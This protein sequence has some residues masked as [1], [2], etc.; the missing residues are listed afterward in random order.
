MKRPRIRK[1]WKCEID[2]KCSYHPDDESLDWFE[3]EDECKSACAESKL[4]SLP[5]ELL[6]EVL[7]Y[8]PMATTLTQ[9]SKKL[10]LEEKPHYSDI[11]EQERQASQIKQL[12][13][14]N[15]YEDV[16][17]MMDLNQGVLATKYLIDNYQEIYK[18]DDA[19]D[20][21]PLLTRFNE[22]F[23]N[24]V[25]EN[26]KSMYLDALFE[27]A[28]DVL[29]ENLYMITKKLIYLYLF[30]IDYDPDNDYLPKIFEKCEIKSVYPYK[31]NEEVIELSS[32]K[33][34]K[35]MRSGEVFDQIME[36]MYPYKNLAILTSLIDAEQFLF[37][38]MLGMNDEYI[39][40]LIKYE[41]LLTD[42]IFNAILRATP[43]IRTVKGYR[44]YDDIL[45]RLSDY[46]SYQLIGFEMKYIKPGITLDETLQHL[47][48]LKFMIKTNLRASDLGLEQLLRDLYD[49]ILEFYTEFELE[50][51]PL[52]RGA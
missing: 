7:T 37:F 12:F 44:S 36:T 48:I 51:F 41:V 8:E 25:L 4:E 33:Y 46:S 11:I 1:H 19:I 49:H 6:H 40:N 50:S 18:M 10:H 2:H 26:R 27:L 17:K 14:E 3:T 23:L 39:K 32:L 16:I 13:N 29:F 9:T 22:S 30:N 5:G 31:F 34:N 42:E 43:S 45:N 35:E 21:E 24:F 28:R 47:K 20:L 15:K 52:I 38:N